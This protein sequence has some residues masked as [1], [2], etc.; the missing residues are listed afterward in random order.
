MVVLVVVVRRG[1]VIRDLGCLA[2]TVGRGRLPATVGRVVVAEGRVVAV[3]A[4]IVMVE[5]TGRRGV[6][7]DSCP[8]AAQSG[9]LRVL[10]ALSGVPN[11]SLKI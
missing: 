2:A 6:L 3:G 4:G 5:V 9:V 7:V 10:L 11:I 8:R 1:P